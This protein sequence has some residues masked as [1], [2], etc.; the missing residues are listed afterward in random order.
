MKINYLIN[1]D[2][3]ARDYLLS[4]YYSKSK[5]YK[6]FLEKKISVNNEII[7]ERKE[8]KSNDILSIDYDE[9]I[10]YIPS[11][12][13]IDILYEDDYFLMINKPK[14]IIIHD[15]SNSLCNAVANYYKKNNIS[16]NVRFAHRLDYDTTGLIIFVKCP[17]CL[18]YLNHFIETHE[19]R[20]EYIAIINGKLNN[21]KGTIDLP[22]GE[23]RHINNKM[24]VSKT[25][26]RAVTHYEV[27]EENN[28]YSKIKVLLETGRTHQIRCHFSHIGHP[29]IGDTLYGDK[30]NL[31]DRYLLHSYRIKFIHPITNKEI[32]VVAKE[33]EDFKIRK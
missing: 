5:I 28:N 8:L 22:I 14:N 25:G 31:S 18:S 16:L 20:R 9:D 6:L 4:F 19:I 33:P 2:I 24:R 29:L 17:L 7:N 30:S 3:N 10:D 12:L 21:K 23:D 15:D 26:K 11:D 1:K 32:E 27:I 13:N